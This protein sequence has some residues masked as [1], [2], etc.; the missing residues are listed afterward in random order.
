MV[1]FCFFHLL[2]FRNCEEFYNLTDGTVLKQRGNDCSGIH[3]FEM[4][5]QGHVRNETTAAALRKSLRLENNSSDRGNVFYTEPSN[6]I[7]HQ[8]QESY[9][10]LEKYEKCTIEKQAEIFLCH[11]FSHGTLYHTN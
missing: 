2:L 1:R 8:G 11:C 10:E 7:R 6:Y 3:P 4:Q 9:V 5:E